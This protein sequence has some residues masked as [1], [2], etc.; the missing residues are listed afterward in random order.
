[1]CVHYIGETTVALQHS[2]AYDFEVDNIQMV[3]ISKL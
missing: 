3:F 2:V 1:M